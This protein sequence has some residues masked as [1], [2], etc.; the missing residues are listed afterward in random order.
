MDLLSS[1]LALASISLFG[2]N[3]GMLDGSHAYGRILKYCTGKLREWVNWWT[4]ASFELW[5]QKPQ[6]REQMQPSRAWPAVWQAVTL[7]DP[8]RLWEA[9]C[10]S[11]SACCRMDAVAWTYSPG[12]AG[13]F[14][15]TP[16]VVSRIAWRSCAVAPPKHTNTTYDFKIHYPLR[17]TMEWNLNSFLFFLVIC[18]PSWNGIAVGISIYCY[19]DFIP[20]YQEEQKYLTNLSSALENRP[21]HE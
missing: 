18:L 7:W 21:S 17:G 20:S 2:G 8:Q 5:F 4:R 14:S 13:T 9:R 16:P 11:L 15:S 10:T 19:S 6:S 3:F 1:S 12:A